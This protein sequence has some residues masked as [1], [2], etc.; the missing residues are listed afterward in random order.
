[1]EEIQD[2]RSTLRLELINDLTK[3]FKRASGYSTVDHGLD[4]WRETVTTLVD[5]VIGLIDED[6]KT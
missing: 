2:R 4:K 3:A 6:K 5:G 1:M